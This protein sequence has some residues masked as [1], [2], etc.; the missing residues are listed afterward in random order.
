MSRDRGRRRRNSGRYVVSTPPVAGG[1]GADE[2]VPAGLRLLTVYEG[3]FETKFHA[4][5]K[6][7]GSIA[8]IP[9]RPPPLA[10]D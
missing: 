5:E 7:P 3:H 4:L 1:F 6:V 8:N 2:P 9:E 10:W